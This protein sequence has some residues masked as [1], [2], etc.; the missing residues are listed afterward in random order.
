VP[1]VAGI[2]TVFVLAAVI[3]ARARSSFEASA[4][5][6][7]GP[8]EDGAAAADRLPRFF[9]F[10]AALTVVTLTA[11]VVEI[12]P[13]PVVFLL[14]CAIAL[15]VNFPDARLQRERL[16]AH[17]HAAMVMVTT[18]LAAGLF[19]GIMSGTGML[20]SMARDIVGVLPPGV[21]RHLPVCCGR[22]DA[23]RLASIPIRSISASCRC[24]RPRRKRPAL[25]PSMSAERRSSDR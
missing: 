25:R 21:L 3:G 18:V 19:A 10:N 23:A 14:A 2:V 24:S 13:L 7:R 8:A 5:S 17:G 16:E 4:L 22:L 11:L 9:W 1:T 20:T 12:L 15:V 6:A